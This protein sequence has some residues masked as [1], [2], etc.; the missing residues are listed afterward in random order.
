MISP[1]KE[2]QILA[3]RSHFIENFI[4]FEGIASFPFIKRGHMSPFL[5]TALRCKM[6]HKNTQILSELPEQL[7]EYIR[8][9]QQSNVDVRPDRSSALQLT[10]TIGQTP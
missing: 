3:Y 8:M 10:G 4:F 6:L 1:P 7:H 2:C 5:I 9:H